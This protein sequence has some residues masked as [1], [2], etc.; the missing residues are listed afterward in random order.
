[1]A[2]KKTKADEPNK[3]EAKVQQVANN[4]TAPLIPHF[5]GI[6]SNC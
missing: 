4:F 2:K 3:E 1:M 6:C 5:R